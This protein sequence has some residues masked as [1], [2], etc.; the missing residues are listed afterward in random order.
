MEWYL[1]K[2]EGRGKLV[3]HFEKAFYSILSFYKH[4]AIPIT[5]SWKEKLKYSTNP[6]ISKAKAKEKRENTQ[7]QEREKSNKPR[8]KGR[9]TGRRRRRTEEIEGNSKKKKKGFVV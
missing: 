6:I 3:G 4:F 8:K 2:G 9:R 7:T 1:I 5:H